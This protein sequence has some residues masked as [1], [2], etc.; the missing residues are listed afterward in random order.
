MNNFTTSLFLYFFSG[1]FYVFSVFFGVELGI[2][3]SKPVYIPALVFYYFTMKSTKN[4]D[5]F[6]SSLVF[7]YIGE[8]LFLINIK[9]YYL[10]GLLF[11]LLPYLI[12][13]YFL[14]VDFVI[15]LKTRKIKID[16]SFWFLSVLLSYLLYS[17]FRLLEFNSNFVMSYMALFGVS[18]LI[19][20]VLTSLLFVY[21]SY[22]KNSYLA[23][24]V[25]SLFMSGLFFVLFTHFLD[26]PIFKIL[27]AFSQTIFYYFYV[28]YFLERSTLRNR[29]RLLQ[30]EF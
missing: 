1:I 16:K 22:R 3:L 12:L 18:I 7:F 13:I 11:F 4:D 30:K 24:A 9:D 14:Y 29:V 21:S 28:K 26:L 19:M 10:L 17:V 25:L 8:M 6:L 15:L 23:F 20:S 2:L 27:A 5:L